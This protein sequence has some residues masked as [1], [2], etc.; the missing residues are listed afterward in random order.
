MITIELLYFDGCPSWRH[1]WTEL[2]GA[3]AELDVDAAVR[4]R[5]I[6][7]VPEPERTGFAGSPTLRID[8][9]DLE[10]YSGPGV[11][12]CRRYPDNAGRGWPSHDLLHE[13]LR[14]AASHDA[15]TA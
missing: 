15:Y 13:R 3:L 11:M 2:G 1:A 7:G 10:D 8:G 6:E 14:A 5:N 9:R 4:L 12:A